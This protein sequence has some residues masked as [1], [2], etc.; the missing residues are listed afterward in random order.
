MGYWKDGISVIWEIRKDTKNKET[1]EI[2]V[3]MTSELLKCI[4]QRSW[5]TRKLPEDR[6]S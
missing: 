2:N 6:K 5:R 3:D 4:F 1:Y